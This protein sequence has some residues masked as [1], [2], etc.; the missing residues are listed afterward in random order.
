MT[1]QLPQHELELMDLFDRD[2][3]QTQR[4]RLIERLSNYPELSEKY[5][6][7]LHLQDLNMGELPEPDPLIRM[8]LMKMAT[9]ETTKIKLGARLQA[10]VHGLTQPFVAGPAALCLVFL[11]G[12]ELMQSSEPS[13]ESLL[14]SEVE[15]VVSAEEQDELEGTVHRDPILKSPTDPTGSGSKDRLVL[16]SKKQVNPEEKRRFEPNKTDKRLEKSEGKQASTEPDDQSE[17]GSADGAGLPPTQMHSKKSRKLQPHR[18]PSTAQ[19]HG[20]Q[21]QPNKEASRANDKEDSLRTLVEA[22]GTQMEDAFLNDDLHVGS[23]SGR[24]G[25]RG[26]SAGGGGIGS[27][28]PTNTKSQLGSK[29]AGQK[30]KTRG[31]ASNRVTPNRGEAA[32]QPRTLKNRKSA[33]RQRVVQEAEP[34]H[35][36]E[37]LLLDSAFKAASDTESPRSPQDRAARSSSTSRPSARA[38]SPNPPEPTHTPLTKREKLS[39][40]KAKSNLSFNASESVKILRFVRLALRA[41]DFAQASTWTEWVIRRNDESLRDALLLRKRV[42]ILQENVTPR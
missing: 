7:Y 6:F 15:S 34:L 42:K 21:N 20:P 22:S 18:K 39:L 25:M 36:N 3:S 5:A 35:M 14:S 19:N 28:R 17:R 37:E 4:D 11:V 12:Y 9:K 26:S 1:D 30:T 2:L 41:N 10:F 32:P 24:V 29:R 31:G 16:N 13:S 23:G 8:R 38:M 33:V 40:L 27:A